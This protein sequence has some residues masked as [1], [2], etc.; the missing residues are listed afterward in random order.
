MATVGYMAAALA[1]SGQLLA[2]RRSRSPHVAGWLNAA[3]RWCGGSGR[4]LLAAVTFGLVALAPM[5]IQA[6]QR[7]GGNLDR[8]QEEVL[9]I[10]DA[11]ARLLATGTPE[12]IAGV[13]DSYTGQFL[14]DLVEAEIKVSR[15]KGKR[16]AAAAA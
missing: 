4:L 13:P 5:V 3:T 11:G 16:R 15:A 8:A 10:E 2:I 12:E 1:A 14:A 6:V 7:A 9:V